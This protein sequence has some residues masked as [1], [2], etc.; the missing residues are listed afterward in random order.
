MVFMVEPNGTRLDSVWFNGHGNSGTIGIVEVS[1]IE[2]DTRK[3]VFKYYIG[4]T[5]GR[6][7]RRNTREIADWGA[8]FYHP[9]GL[10]LFR[11]T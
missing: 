10:T 2:R 11:R 4:I 5:D 8:P 6:D 3:M 1:Y 9:A 7:E